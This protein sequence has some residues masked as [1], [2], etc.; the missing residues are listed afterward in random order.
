MERMQ[1]LSRFEIST[2]NQSVG[3]VLRAVVNME[4][5]KEEECLALITGSNEDILKPCLPSLGF[6]RFFLILHF[7][8]FL[9]GCQYIRIALVCFLF[10]A[11]CIGYACIPGG[12]DSLCHVDI[13]HDCYKNGRYRRNINN[14]VCQAICPPPSPV[15]SSPFFL[16][17]IFFL[18]SSS[19]L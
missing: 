7:S 16:N 12:T 15:F 10:P 18:H 9:A 5:Y 14:I 4:V 13:F 19:N 8:I 2:Y 1:D 17:M 6:G 11:I 3:A